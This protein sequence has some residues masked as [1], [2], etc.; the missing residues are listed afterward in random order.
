MEDSIVVADLVVPSGV[1]I[2]DA[3]DEVV[4]SLVPTRTAMKLGEE[5]AVATEEG[6]E[7]AD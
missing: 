1:A 3:P 6:P 2:L 7:E 5:E 4:V